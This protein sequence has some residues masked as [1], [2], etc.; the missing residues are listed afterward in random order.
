MNSL[1]NNEKIIEILKIRL[2]KKR[3]IHSRNVADE[4]RRLAARYGGDPEKAYTAG[5]L[6]DICKEITPEEQKHYVSLS[7]RDV[8]EEEK[9]VPA[10]WHAVAGAYYSEFV[11]GFHDEDILNAVRYHTVGRGGMSLLEE[12]VY[13][14]DLTSADRSYKD[15]TRMRKLAAS[16]L[17]K[18]MLEAVKFSV[19]DVMAKGSLIPVHTIDAYNYYSQKCKGGSQ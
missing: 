15:V 5:L 9:K 12:I 16:D 11:L 13:M 7:L 2:S 10:L 3:Y 8:S 17:T 4:A 18:A 6:H 14:A 1:D 19:S